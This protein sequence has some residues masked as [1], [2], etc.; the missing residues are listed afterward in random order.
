MQFDLNDTIVAAASAPGGAARAVV[1]VSGP[2]SGSV[3]LECFHQADGAALLPRSGPPMVI[4]GRV[5]VADRD[6]PRALSI[7]ADLFWWPTTRSYTRQPLGELQLPGSPPLVR[8]VI[9]E[10]CTA[11]ARPA[12]PGEFTLRAFLA[13]RLD[14]MQAEAVLGVIDARGDAA[15]Q[16]ALVQLAGGL[17]QPLHQLREELLALLAELEA[18]LDFADEDIE[19]ISPAELQRRLAAAQSTVAATCEQ[20]RVRGDSS[21]CPRVALIGPPNVGKSSLFNVLASRYAVEAAHAPAIV[22]AAAGTTRDYLV[23]RL[24]LDGVAVELVDTAGEDAAARSGIEADAQRATD[25]AR[26]GAE[27]LLSCREAVQVAGT[28]GDGADIRAAQAIAT[29]PDPVAQLSVATKVDQLPADRLAS[30]LASKN[31]VLPV[32]ILTGAGLDELASAI[33]YAAVELQ[34]DEGGRIVAATAIRVADSLRQADA[35]LREGVSL[36]AVPGREDLVAA[37][38]RIALAA[39]GEVVGAVY[40]DDV[41]DRIFSQ[42]CIGK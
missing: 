17:S 24:D 32:S 31:D 25:A 18:G 19:F 23:V 16:T 28:S 15:L 8:A 7:P 33:R 21:D 9:D 34:A 30:L 27:I 29:A 1:R 41:L 26:R 13:G 10:L 3:I 12:R 39:L 38:L 4:P 20:L 42:F 11:G 6:L 14:L 5:L 40:V 22:S 2:K 35:A 36:A 37:E